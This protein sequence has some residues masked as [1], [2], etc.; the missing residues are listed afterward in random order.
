MSGER[1]TADAH[2]LYAIAQSNDYRTGMLFS[3]QQQMD[4]EL[5]KV[6]ESLSAAEAERAR[7][8]A[9]Q[10]QSPTSEERAPSAEPREASQPPTATV[11]R[12]GGN[13]DAHIDEGIMRQLA[14]LNISG[15]VAA[16]DEHVVRARARRGAASSALV[17]FHHRRLF[18]VSLTPCP[19]RSL[20]YAG[21]SH[22]VWRQPSTSRCARTCCCIA[23]FLVLM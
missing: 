1:T 20:R 5:S 3:L 18:C 17:T 15:A 9:A 2:T 19:R 21:G 14:Q 8:G 11:A 10:V 4:R 13:V 12:R 23:A 7:E 22:S 16:A 6:E